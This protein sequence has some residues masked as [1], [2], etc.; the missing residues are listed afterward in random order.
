LSYPAESGCAASALS[1]EHKLHQH[2]QGQDHEH[3]QLRRDGAAGCAKVNTSSSTVLFVSDQNGQILG[4]TTSAEL[5]SVRLAGQ[6]AGC[7]VHAGPDNGQS[8]E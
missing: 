6:H 2:D 3:L 7:D 5:R 4:R 8:S 1:Y